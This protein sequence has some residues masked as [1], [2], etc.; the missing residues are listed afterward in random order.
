[1][2]RVLETT[3]KNTNEVDAFGSKTKSMH[4]REL[5][6]A[7][8]H[9]I[10]TSLWKRAEA[11]MRTYR[12][13]QVEQNSAECGEKLRLIGRIESMT[14]KYVSCAPHTISVPWIP[15]KRDGDVFG[16]ALLR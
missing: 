10:V 3:V 11:N 16:C 6:E 14:G 1:M 5:E 15:C 9:I 7:M 13:R 8:Y 4:Y 2:K 12:V